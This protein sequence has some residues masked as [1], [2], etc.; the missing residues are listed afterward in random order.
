MSWSRRKFIKS[1]LFLAASAA[2]AD[3]FYFERFFIE[4]NEF[5]IGSTNSKEP[6]LKLI[7]ISDLHL[8]KLSTPL[9]KLA[10]KINQL[11]PDLILIT[12]DAIDDGTNINLLDQFLKLIEKSIKKVAILGNWEYWGRV[13][14]EEL[15]AIYKK[16]NCDLLINQAKQYALKEKLISVT[17]IDDYVGGNADI[18]LALENY[19]K[20][21]FHLVLNHCP[22]YSDKL[23]IIKQKNINVDLILSGHTHGGQVNLFGIIPFL[24][25]GSGQYVKGWYTDAK[26]TMYV[27]KG[28]G[29]SLLPIRFGARAEIAVFH[30]HI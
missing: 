1:G 24:P 10:S 11:A 8:T 17:G 5:Q 27:S 6:A 23:A 9:K 15:R 26:K 30:L 20:G 25:Q 21:D 28:I 18:E 4:I 7:Q 2:I 16:H 12:G 13:N 19:K 3:A 22:E 29:T 14:L